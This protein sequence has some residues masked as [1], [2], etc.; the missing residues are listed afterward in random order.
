MALPPLDDVF[1]ATFEL[2]W[3]G[4]KQEPKKS[5]HFHREVSRVLTSMDVA[6]EN[7]ASDDVDI[8]VHASKQRG[9]R[10]AM[11]VDGPSHF[12]SNKPR[13]LNGASILKTRV[14]RARGWGRVVRVS[15]YEW[16]DLGNATEAKRQY[17]RGLLKE[18]S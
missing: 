11:E 15:Y 3:Q 1:T 5:S 12:T 13:R 14:L 17:L 6:H 9:S 4:Q 16:S 2:A 8:C 7:E 18:V 10:V